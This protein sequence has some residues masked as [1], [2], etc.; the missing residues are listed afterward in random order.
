MLH[1]Q[2]D[3]L[4]EE[5]IACDQLYVVRMDVSDGSSHGAA[6]CSVPLGDGNDAGRRAAMA[7][8]ASAPLP[9]LEVG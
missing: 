7:M 6:R 3:K 1:P 4:F 2:S 5:S 9:H 8:V